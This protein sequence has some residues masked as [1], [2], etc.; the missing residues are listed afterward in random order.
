M[1]NSRHDPS[2]SWS[3]LTRIHSHHDPSSSKFIL[4]MIIIIMIHSHHDHP[5]HDPF[6]S[7]SILA[8]IHPHHDP[9]S[10]ISS[11]SWSIHF[12]TCHLFQLSR[13]LPLETKARI[14]KLVQHQSTS[15]FDSKSYSPV[16]FKLRL[17]TKTRIGKLVQPTPVN[18]CFWSQ[19][20]TFWDLNL[21]PR[22]YKS[23]SGSYPPTLN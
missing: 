8:M 17:E 21:I 4:I 15:T 13:L 5:N 23:R 12:R 18:T 22:S 6:S 14:G 10:S 1:I 19:I 9:F 20:F 7:W 3:S 2:S 11:S 16:N